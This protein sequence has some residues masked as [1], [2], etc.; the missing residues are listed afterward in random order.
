MSNEIILKTD[1]VSIGYA[2][3]KEAIIIASNIN[4]ELEKGSLIAMI[5]ENGIGKTTL[6]RT[7]SGIQKPIAGAV[8]INNKNIS[9]YSNLEL[10]Q[11]LSLVLTEKIPEIGRA[12]V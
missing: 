5:G 2:S 7:L 12:H 4:I 9:E 11:N 6:L 1:N 3:K 10:S 8:F